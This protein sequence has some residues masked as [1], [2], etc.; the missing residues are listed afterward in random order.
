M[1][2][3]GFSASGEVGL[4]SG[5]GVEEGTKGKA[6]RG[7]ISVITAKELT[8]GKLSAN[9]ATGIIA[10]SQAASAAIWLGVW[11]SSLP[12]YGAVALVKTKAK[13]TAKIILIHLL[14]AK[15]ALIFS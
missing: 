1:A 13:T 9:E 3:V 12:K 2:V 4:S 7:T 15:S 5:F 11:G 6:K 14:F 10:C 8:S